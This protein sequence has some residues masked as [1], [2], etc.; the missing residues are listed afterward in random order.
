MINRYHYKETTWVDM[1]QPTEVEIESILHEFHIRPSIANELVSPSVKSRVELHNDYIYLILHFPAFKHSH[2]FE[3][4]QEVDFI[5]GKNFLITAR[6]DT[7]D[8]I[9]KFAKIVEVNT[10]LDRG[11]EE[12]CT[13]VIFFGI[14]QEIYTSLIHELEY[15]ESWLGNI[16]QGIFAGE[17]KEMVYSISEVSRNLLNF[18]KATDFHAEAL[19]SLDVYGGKLFAEHF[20]YHVRRIKNEYSKIAHLIQNNWDSMTEL[21]ETNNALLSTKQ[22]EIMKNLTIVSFITLPLSL[23]AALFGMNTTSTPLVGSGNDFWVIAS[24]M[25]ILACLFLVF[26]KYKKWF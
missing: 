21:R 5:V 17:E 19:D 26:F 6:Y 24:I 11:I 23:F 8:P 18:K 20:S 15:I 2:S 22:N 12:N 16:E 9:D 10:I 14:L 1:T 13:T 4:K 7:I 3:N 25:A